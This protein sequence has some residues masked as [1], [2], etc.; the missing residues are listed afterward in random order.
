MDDQRF[1]AFTRAFAAGVT[2]RAAVRRLAAGFAGL[3]L[4]AVS[5]G[6]SAAAPNDCAVFCAD[7]PGP[8]GAQCRQ[9]CKK[10][11]GG[12][13][14]VCFDASSGSFS[15]RDLQA[16]PNNCGGCDAICTEPFSACA[17]GS[18]ACPSGTVACG[19]G[20][21]RTCGHGEVFIQANCTCRSCA[22]LAGSATCNE[23][24]DCPTGG[25]LDTCQNGCC[26]VS[27]GSTALG[28][29]PNSPAPSCCSGM[30]GSDGRCA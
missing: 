20:C 11:T 1:D 6:Q 28:C 9:V 10:C 3:G 12:P 29:L 8:R 7:Q 25:A 15:C 23:V 14:A 21:V 30:C 4:T 18:C 16:D 26:C 17:G 13:P 24:G 22:E 19:G 27:A 2:R 5:H